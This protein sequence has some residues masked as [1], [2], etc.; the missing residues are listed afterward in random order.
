MGSE[1]CIRD[2]AIANVIGSNIANIALVLGLAALVRPMAVDSRLVRREVPALILLQL[3]IPAFAWNGTIERYEGFLLLVVGVIYNLLLLSEARRRRQRVLDEDDEI[4]PEDGRFAYYIGLLVGGIV[5]IVIGS[6]LFVDGAKEIALRLGLS[7]RYVGLTVVALG[8][9][10]PEVATSVMSAYRNQGDLAVGNA[11]GSNILNITMVLALTA[12]VQPIV[13]S[14]A[15]VNID[16]AV[17]LG[18]TLLL[19]PM[20]LRDRLLG[21]I[22]GALLTIGYLVYV[23]STPT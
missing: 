3:M 5:I 7:Q 4:I 16:F 12:M 1:M 9:S 19:I 14:S 2:R 11:L 22:E 13:M 8:T 23:F 20:V 21:R 17:A 6:M 10:A 18:V 15:D